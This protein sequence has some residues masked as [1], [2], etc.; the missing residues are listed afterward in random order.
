[1][2]RFWYLCVAEYAGRT[3]TTLVP[4]AHRALARIRL[5]EAAPTIP[6]HLW[7]ITSMGMV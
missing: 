7:T 6:P 2:P 5:R 4:S 3:F 1:M